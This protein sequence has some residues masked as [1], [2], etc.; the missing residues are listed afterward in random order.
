MSADQHKSLQEY[1]FHS[2]TLGTGK[3]MLLMREHP[4]TDF[5][6]QILAAALKNLAYDKQCEGSRAAYL[7]R[8]IKKSRH[9]DWLIKTILEKLLLKKP[10]DYGT[11]QLCEL[12]LCFYHDGILAAKDTLLERFDKS[13]TDG[14]ELCG[15]DELLS[16]TGIAGLLRIAEK[17]GQLP[18]D[19]RSDY[20]DRWRV[21]DFQKAHP[22]IDVY[23]ELKKAGNTNIAIHNYLDLIL[24][25]EQRKRYRRSKI[26]PYS[27]QDIEDVISED[28]RFCH[29]WRSRVELMNEADIA[30]V[31]HRFLEEKDSIRQTKYLRF[32][33]QT[34]Y[35]FDYSAILRLAGKRKIRDSRLISNAVKA[36]GYFKGDDIRALALKKFSSVKTP[37]E[38]LELLISNYQAGDA[39]ML[40]ELILRSDDF[41][42]VHD[43]AYGVIAIYRANPGP[44][45][46]APLEALYHHMNCSI[47][48]LDLVEMLEENDV[49]SDEILKE[50]AFDSEER[51]RAI[52][53]RINKAKKQAVS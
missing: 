49:L 30:H 12:A 20:A 31:A 11:D 16:M 19:V 51:I 18:E 27:I 42:H 36:L 44:D 4:Q 6:R 47:H 26:T 28:T 9:K 37:S 29:F 23:G 48:R 45:C 35:P 14:Y 33:S 46:K 53:R 13:F 15:K 17:I 25:E 38:Y 8:L 43:L 5:S 7:Y 34:K 21:D 32:F 10:D 39:D 52:S 2:L 1:F 41:H 40:T 24:A 3:A 50:M 22:A